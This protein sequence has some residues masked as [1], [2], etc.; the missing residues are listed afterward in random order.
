MHIL[1]KETNKNGSFFSKSDVLSN[2]P[3]LTKSEK[4]LRALLWKFCHSFSR[5]ASSLPG[6]NGNI[7]YFS[8]QWPKSRS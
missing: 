6:S 5:Q 2:T 7:F 3:K 1:N 4:K 8:F